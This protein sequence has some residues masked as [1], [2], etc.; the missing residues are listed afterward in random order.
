MEVSFVQQYDPCVMGKV[1]R[2]IRKRKKKTQEVMSG[3]AGIDRTH[4]ARIEAGTLV[5]SVETLWKIAEA[6]DLRLSELFRLVEEEL[7]RET[8]E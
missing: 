6:L 4:W 2:M 3:F 5:A 8:Q 7:G 1:I